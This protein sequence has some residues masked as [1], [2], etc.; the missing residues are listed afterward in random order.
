MKEN[1][2]SALRWINTFAFLLTIIINA[3][4]EL[5]PIN[6]VSTG[7]VSADFPNLF[8]PAPYTFSIWGLIYF[9]LLL[10]TISQ[11]GF[12]KKLSLSDS[13]IKTIGPW[14]IISSVFNSAWILFWHYYKIGFALL[15]ILGLLLSLAVI[16]V[17]LS[18][19]LLNTKESICTKLPFSVYFSWISIAVIANAAAFFVSINWNGFG[20]SDQFW[21]ITMIFVGLII[22][23]ITTVTKRAPF[24]ALTMVWAFIGILVKH[25][26]SSGFNKV[27]PAIIWSSSIA[28]AL[29]LITSVLVLFT[30]QVNPQNKVTGKESIQ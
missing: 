14:F 30:S 5:V 27:Y 7:E 26:S 13:L 11:I 19:S 10:F 17:R 3:L 6:G 8:A 24:Y 15:C 25:I 4:A 29:L 16:F 23:I 22:G 2:V 9:L 12:I 21:T 20:L 1:R 28:A 18:N